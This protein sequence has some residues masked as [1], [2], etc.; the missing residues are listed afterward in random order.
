[1]VDDLSNLVGMGDSLAIGRSGDRK[2]G[3]SRN[4]SIKEYR[5]ISVRWFVGQISGKWRIVPRWNE[6]S[7]Q[8]CVFRYVGYQRFGR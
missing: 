6:Q 4:Q 2:T 7:Q 3:P 8:R 1:M 5:Q